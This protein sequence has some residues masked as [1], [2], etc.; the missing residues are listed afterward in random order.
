MKPKSIKSSRETITLLAKLKG[1][2]REASCMV[3]AIKLSL[4][5]FNIAQFVGCD[6]IQAPSDLPDGEYTVN[7]GDRKIFVEKRNGVWHHGG[8]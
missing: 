3:S 5:D 7:I 6:V 8:L 4:P 1:M 2:G